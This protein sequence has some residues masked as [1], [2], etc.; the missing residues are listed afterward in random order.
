MKRLRL[1]IFGPGSGHDTYR[2]A[3]EL[4]DEVTKIMRDRATRRDPLKA[5]LVD[6]LFQTHDPALVA[7]AYEMSQES[8]IYKGPSLNGSGH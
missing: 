3:I 1:W 2:R 8:R 4:A 5:V 7:D 6:L